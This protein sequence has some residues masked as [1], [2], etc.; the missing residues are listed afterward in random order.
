MR[1]GCPFSPSSAA[2]SGCIRSN[3]LPSYTS[4]IDRLTRS[5][6]VSTSVG[7]GPPS[8]SAP[9][10]PPC[11]AARRSCSSSAA[12]V[13]SAAACAITASMKR[14]T[15][16]RAPPSPPE[17]VWV[18]PVPVCPY[19]KTVTLYPAMNFPVYG[20]TNWPY[21]CSCV[22]CSPK[23]WS[24]VKAFTGRSRRGEEPRGVVVEPAR[25]V[26][27]PGRVALGES[28]PRSSSSVKAT[29]LPCT[30]R[31]LSPCARSFARSGR[32]RTA[33]RKAERETSALASAGR[34]RSA[35]ASA[36]SG[37]GPPALMG[38]WA[39]AQGALAQCTVP[40]RIVW[41]GEGTTSGQHGIQNFPSPTLTPT[42]KGKCSSLA[43]EVLIK[44]SAINIIGTEDG[45]REEQEKCDSCRERKTGGIYR[46]ARR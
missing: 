39:H 10:P 17:T 16:P 32:Q 45:P 33:T 25:G 34:A 26:E 23:T 36:A 38:A 46:P 22:L 43:P 31:M 44:L 15:T 13:R 42:N 4:K 2:R 20:A 11:S 41:R 14:G 6:T 3:T 27:E 24:K 37:T 5:S 19:A 28:E 8:C 9:A 30:V 18:L 40:K 21:S 29:E 35:L 1:A 7:R 12:R